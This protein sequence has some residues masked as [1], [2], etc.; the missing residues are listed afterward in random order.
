[1]LLLILQLVTYCLSLQ[2]TFVSFVPE[3]LPATVTILLT[4]A[5][6]RMS[7]RNVMV[8]DLPSVETL[9]AITLLATDKTGT[10]TKN[11]MTVGFIWTGLN[12]FYTQDSNHDLRC[13]SPIDTKH[14]GV[15]EIL[16]ISILCSSVT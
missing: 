12:Y 5:A 7:Q 3:G 10:L 14:A 6:K 2:G 13:A 16:H 15:N 9:G 1:M 4:I 8:K 11:Q